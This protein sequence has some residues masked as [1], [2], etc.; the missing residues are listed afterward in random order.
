MKFDVQVFTR[1]PVPGE[2]KTRLIP[3]LGADG[4]AALHRRLLDLTLHTATA[5]GV[6]SVQLWCAPDAS[7]PFLQV[8]A[9]RF[10]AQL[11]AQGTGDLG[12]RMQEAIAAANAEGHAAVLIGSDCPGLQPQ[13]LRA[14][15]TALA[16]GC[17]AAFVPAEDGGYVLV[18][19]S[20]APAILF[21]RIEWGTPRVMAQTRERLMQLGWR[22]RELAPRWDVDRP[23]DF[24]RL[25][26]EGWS[27]S[28][29]QP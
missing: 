4:A 13:D 5:S 11:R 28:D 21:D 6:G 12:L 22:W 10:G 14:A 25:A 2:V 19:A 26:R 9:R 29:T 27:C 23:E 20:Q 15:A 17:D 8:C 24:E 3:R 18:A 7:H 1:A 16:G